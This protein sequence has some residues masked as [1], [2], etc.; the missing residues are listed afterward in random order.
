MKPQEV[1][2]VA[3]QVAGEEA[4]H[5]FMQYTGAPLLSPQLPPEGG[6]VAGGAWG[7]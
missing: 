2:S 4:W 5:L 1:V 6:V 3:A 7:P